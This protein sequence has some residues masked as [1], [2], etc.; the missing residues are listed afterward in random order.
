MNPHYDCSYSSSNTSN[1]LPSQID[2]L[3][4]V[5]AYLQ[6]ARETMG[7]NAKFRLAA[8]WNQHDIDEYQL[9]DDVLLT[10]NKSLM[11]KSHRNSGEDYVLF[12]Y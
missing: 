5:I 11:E 1:K 2:T 10:G 7:G 9:V 6:K 4:D 8:D 12:V 3:D